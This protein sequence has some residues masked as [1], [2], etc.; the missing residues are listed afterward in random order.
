MQSTKK[1]K[2]VDVRLKV[3]ALLG[4]RETD[5]LV[6]EKGPCELVMMLCDATWL[7]AWSI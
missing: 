6:E 4:V 5:I 1:A 3:R 2:T 7:A